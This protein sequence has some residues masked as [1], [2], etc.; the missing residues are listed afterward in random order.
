MIIVSAC[1]AGK[2]CRWNGKNKEDAR[3]KKMVES[4][5]A[6]AACP[7][8]LGGL[9]TPRKPCGMFA[10]TGADV[11]SGNAKVESVDDGEDFT[12]PFVKGAEEFLKIARENKIDT[13][14]MYT[15]SPSCGCGRTWKL[16]NALAN[17]IVEGDG[18]AAALLR[19]NGIKV[20]AHDEFL[21]SK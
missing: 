19:K 7:E 6:I 8:E 9:P 14:V 17:A 10:G 15:P 5:E 4:G 21:N 18:V 2:N 20:V 16:D 13:A 12:E 3:I 1:I 11:I